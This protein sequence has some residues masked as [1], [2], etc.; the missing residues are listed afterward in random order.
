[1]SRALKLPGEKKTVKYIVVDG[2]KKEIL[3]MARDGEDRDKYNSDRLEEIRS[4]LVEIIEK[5]AVSANWQ[6]KTIANLKLQRE[7]ELIWPELTKSLPEEL[8]FATSWFARARPEMDENGRLIVRSESSLACKSLDC[9]E[10]RNYLRK[11]VA[12]YTGESL[13]E[14]DFKNGDFVPRKKSSC[15]ASEAGSQQKRGRRSSEKKNNGRKNNGSSRQKKKMVLFGSRISDNRR[16]FSLDD[17]PEEGS[18]V[19]EGELFEVDSR[20][21]RNGKTLYMFSM[22]DYISSLKIKVFVNDGSEFARLPKEGET[23]RAAGELQYDR[24]SRETTMMADDINLIPAQKREDNAEEKRVELHL[25]TKMSQMDSVIDAKKAVKR[26]SS[27]G[28]EA[29]AVTD[30]GVVQAFPDAYEAAREEEIKL[31]MGLEAYLVDDGEKI[32]VN[33]GDSRLNELSFVIFD[34]ETTGLESSQDRIIEIGAVR[35]EDGEIVESYSQLIN[36][37][38]VISGK[39]EDLTGI[40]NADLKGAPTVDEVLEDFLAFCQDAVLVAHNADFDYS[41]LRQE[42]LRSDC[43]IPRKP[44][45]DTLALSRALLPEL[46]SHKL[47]KLCDHFEIELEDHHRAET[48]AEATARLLLRLLDRA[49]N[50]RANPEKLRD[51]NDLA[52]NID[53]KKQN[54]RHAVLLARNKSGLKDLYFLVSRSHIHNFYGKPRILKSELE[55]FRDNLLVGSACEAGEVFQAVLQQKSEGE[56]KKTADFYDYLEIQPPGNNKFMIPDRVS[57]LAE[58]K[59]I[60]EKIYELGQKLDKPV[61]A[62]SDAHYLDEEDAIYRQILQAGQDFDDADKQPPIY[63]KTTEEMLSACDYLGEERS[64]EVVIEN[65]K[66]ISGM[67]ERLNPIPEGLHTPEIENA[68]EK[69]RE[70]SFAKAHRLYGSPLP[71][72][73]KIRLEEELSAI[74]DNGYAVIYLISHKLVQ[75]SLDDGYLVG[76]RG[77]VGSSLAAYMMDITEVNPLPP[78]HRCPD[79]CHAEFVDE[80]EDIVGVDLGDKTCPECG[81]EMDAD[82]FDIPFPVFMGFDGNKVPD[83]DLNFS[84]EYQS[85]IHR[86]TEKL[87]GEEYVFRAGTISTIADRTAYGFVKGYIQDRDLEKRSTE[88]NRLVDGCTGVKRTTG[89]HPGGLMVVPRDMDIH[90][91][92]PVQRPANDQDSGVKTTHFDY[93]AISGRIL[94]L[95]LLGHDDPTSIRKLQD[96]TGKDPLEISLDDEN[97]MSIFSGIDELDMEENPLDLEVGTLGV[98]EFGTSFVRGMLTET[99]PNTFAELVRISGLSHGT[100]VWL[101]NARQLIRSNTA[102]LKDVISV[103]DD[104]MNYLIQKGI[105]EKRSF[106]IMEDARKGRGLNDKQRQILV[107]HGVP[108]WYIESC[109]KIKYMFP[110]AHAAAYVMMAFRIAYFKVYHPAEFYATYFSNNS[111]CYEAG[112]INRGYEYVLDHLDSLRE[113]GNDRTPKENNQLSLLHI[114]VEA[115]NRGLEFLPVNIYESALND[116][117]LKEDDRLLPPLVA[118]QGLGSTAAENIVQARKNGEFMSVEN[119]VNRTGVSST[120][121]ESLRENGTFENMPEHNQLS[122][123]E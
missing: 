3:I 73:V 30:H 60:N 19:V 68:D 6:I 81:E 78:H 27:W 63:F 70:N 22:T 90:D 92:T 112:L 65:P 83:I 54:Y 16:T 46:K 37:E 104:I 110:K 18:A 86:E 88:I 71:E 28:H 61:V 43:S 64:R 122:L 32:V 42:C 114:I 14:I 116:F 47:N 1:M 15:S 40:S 39:I 48:D 72:R 44:L 118:V 103:R 120:V 91:F 4:R 77:S 69:V 108:D 55:K 9:R 117:Q 96:L 62:T 2:D 79:C 102:E 24:Y 82:G 52:D 49:E 20:K 41:F 31:I 76:S 113:K 45:L 75:K 109:E 95:D 97:T 59:K 26:A 5:S 101:N 38:R 89:Q 99:R 36:P 80:R 13:Q 10:L 51:I 23:I 53:W 87:F 11:K 85:T 29:L 8:G 100:D 21:T 67:I 17:I 33:P 119:F 74:I 35:V 25:H 115:M 98:P 93:H 12:R 7:I 106:E 84:G 94:K 58:L 50:S 111:S 56:L 57:S 107:D 66:K 105:A 34:L 123:F 121:V